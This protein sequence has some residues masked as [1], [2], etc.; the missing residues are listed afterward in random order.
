MKSF[1]SFAYAE[2]AAA[3]EFERLSQAL[4]ETG[5]ASSAQVTCVQDALNQL[6][7]WRGTL[8]PG[9]VQQLESKVAAKLEGWTRLFAESEEDEESRRALAGSVTVQTVFDLLKK[10]T[11]SIPTSKREFT[12]L[13]NQVE[14]KAQKEATSALQ[15]KLDEAVLKLECLS[16][17]GEEASSAIDAFIDTCRISSNLFFS[18]KLNNEARPDLGPRARVF[19]SVLSSQL[20]PFLNRSGA[21]AIFWLTS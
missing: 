8:R 18:D 19:P 17:G 11:S 13:L 1:W 9:F 16:G 21:V 3:P 20:Q 5:P 10:G 2:Q 6:P 4:S 14:T 15:A 12:R 7:G